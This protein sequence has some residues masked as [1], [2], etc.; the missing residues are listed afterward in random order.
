[1]YSRSLPIGRWREYILEDGMEL[2]KLAPAIAFI[3]V[4][5]IGYVRIIIIAASPDRNFRKSRREKFAEKAKAQHYHASGVLVKSRRI[6]R[7]STDDF[8]KEQKKS[9]IKVGYYEYRVGGVTYRK[10]YRFK[11][12]GM[13]CDDM[14]YQIDV[15]YNPNRPSK[16]VTS[17]D[18]KGKAG[19][20]W[21]GCLLTVLLAIATFYVVNWLLGVL[22]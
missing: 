1:M 19:H 7:S 13:H 6:R 14:P 9:G 11:Y 12:V 3:L 2:I 15:Y 16:C 10:R 22:L 18:L 17:L 20:T 4:L 8:D 21:N 5:V